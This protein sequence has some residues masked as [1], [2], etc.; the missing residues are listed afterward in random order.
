MTSPVT[1]LKEVRFELDKVEW[2][3]REQ[4]IRLTGLVI[5]ISIGVGLFIGALD[6]IFFKIMTIIL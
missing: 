1:F 4:L 2:P 6:F 5:V 3:T